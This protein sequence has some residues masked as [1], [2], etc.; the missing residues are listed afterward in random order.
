V[1][2]KPNQV[3]S[4]NI[5]P[6]AVQ[7]VDALESSFGPVPHA[8]NADT[9]KIAGDAATVGGVSADDLQFGNGIDGALA[10]VIDANQNG[11]LLLSQTQI[12][13][14]CSASPTLQWMPIVGPTTSSDFPFEVW[15]NGAHTKIAGNGP[16][17]IDNVPLSQDDTVQIHS[18]SN[19]GVVSHVVLSVSWDATNTE[20]AIAF[21]TQENVDGGCLSP[22]P[23]PSGCSDLR[24]G[25]VR[26]IHMGLPDG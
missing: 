16:I 3:K 11:D 17:S 4:K 23:T 2:L 5:A 20:C 14:H 10:G 7:G 18:W 24:A 19:T 13:I 22:A 25:R 9:A 21:T 12:P 6:D 15:I 26:N 1:K 8:N